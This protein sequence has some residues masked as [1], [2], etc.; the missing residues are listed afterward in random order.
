MAR[1]Q[2]NLRN[3]SRA[4]RREYRDGVKRDFDA[5]VEQDRAMFDS[6]EFLGGVYRAS[7]ATPAVPEAE[8]KS[9][10]GMLERF[11]LARV[12]R[13]L[14]ELADGRAPTGEFG[15]SFEAEED[16]DKWREKADALENLLATLAR[17]QS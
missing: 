7:D 10:D 2:Y 15:D 8:L 17:S 14:R 5:F 4:E 9:L 3:S 6:G 11:G 1:T 13:S 12:L 16:K